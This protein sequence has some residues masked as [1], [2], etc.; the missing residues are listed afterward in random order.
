M[1]GLLIDFEGIDGSGTETQSKLLQQRFRETH[2]IASL[3]RYPDLNSAWGRIIDDFLHKR[4]DIDAKAQFLTFAADIYKDQERIAKALAQGTS[5]ITDRYVTST[6]AYQCSKGMPLNAALAIVDALGFIAPDLIV[7][8]DV[9]ADVSMQRKQGEKGALDRHESD[10]RLLEA[11]RGAYMQLA[12][13]KRVSKNWL[14]VDG[15]RSREE[16]GKEVAA[17]V[18]KMLER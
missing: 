5:I 4:R 10:R 7:L 13:E 3:Y 18:E 12:N 9:P 6:I 16:I 11:V 17:H 8:L 2:R 15:R 14:V 1:A